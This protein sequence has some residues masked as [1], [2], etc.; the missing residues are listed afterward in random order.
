MRTRHLWGAGLAL[1]AALGLA[2]CED[3]PLAGQVAEPDL[4]GFIGVNDDAW[5]GGDLPIPDTGANN[6]APDAPELP[7]TQDSGPSDAAEDEEINAEVVPEDFVRPTPDMGSEEAD[8]NVQDFFQISG[9][10]D[11]LRWSLK[12]QD[13][14]LTLKT[15]R[16]FIIY[17]INNICGTSFRVRVPHESDLF[18]V[19][20]QKDGE[21]WIFLPDCPGVGAPAE[22][23]L[24]PQEGWLRGWFWEPA[25]HEAR[26]QRC[27]VTFDADA[28]YSVIGYGLTRAEGSND[29]Q[30]FPLTDPILIDL[31][32]VED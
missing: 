11:C 1:C 21:P 27:G 8:L 20:I 25:D 2:G 29:S 26:L 17:Q 9:Q 22:L 15:D 12:I 13:T 19:G 24:A 6:G 31:R 7:P 28:Q 30:L 23:T 18:P 3:E 4:G 10:Q 14:E 16:V 32:G 5:S